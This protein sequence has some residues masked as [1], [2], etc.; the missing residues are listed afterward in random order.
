M[1]LFGRQFDPWV[2]VPQ[3]ARLHWNERD[4]GKGRQG[5]ENARPNGKP[6][7]DHQKPEGCGW[8]GNAITHSKFFV[9]CPRF[10]DMTWAYGVVLLS[11]EAKPLDIAVA[12]KLLVR[13]ILRPEISTSND[14]KIFEDPKE[15]KIIGV[16]SMCILQQEKLPHSF[17][18]KLGTKEWF[19]GLKKDVAIKWL[20]KIGFNFDS[21]SPNEIEFIKTY[22]PRRTR[23]QALTL[24]I[25]F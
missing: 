17:L 11:R 8:T 2:Q 14:F 16:L 20:R 19:K 6:E 1:G 21:P 3:G 9:P 15:K 7:N 10:E 4:A 12:N 22:L 13:G 24:C 5:Q 25:L 23:K 18:E